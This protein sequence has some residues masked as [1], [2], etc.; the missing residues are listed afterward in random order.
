MSRCVPLMM[1]LRPLL[2]PL[3]LVLAACTTPL[4]SQM[5]A[6]SQP[7]A[8]TIYPLGDRP[9]VADAV[10]RVEQLTATA[11]RRCTGVLIAS[12]LVA[13]ASHCAQDSSP[14]ALRVFVATGDARPVL[15]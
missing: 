7:L 2:V 1:P 4:P 3:C 13:T 9:E 5:P 12:D 10:V 8:M 15:E 14:A 11:A 6:K